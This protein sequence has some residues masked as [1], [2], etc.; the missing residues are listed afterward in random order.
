MCGWAGEFQVSGAGRGKTLWE[1][2]R[3]RKRQKTTTY[4]SA[5]PDTATEPL[6]KGWKR[7]CWKLPG[8]TCCCSVEGGGIIWR[9]GKDESRKEGRK[10]R[11]KV[12][13]GPR[14]GKIGDVGE[15]FGKA[16]E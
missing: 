4:F 3:E 7:S 10:K 13:T 16:G 15:A 1:G 2:K 8:T 9:R 12:R 5:C 14:D 11:S 6:G